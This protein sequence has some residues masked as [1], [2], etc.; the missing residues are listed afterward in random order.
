VRDNI[1]LGA[2]GG[3]ASLQQIEQAARDANIWDFIMSLPQGLETECGQKGTKLSGGQKQR[4][5]IAR[6]LVR[7]PAVLLLDEATSALDSASEKAVLEAL[8]GVVGGR[9]VISVA[10]VSFSSGNRREVS[11]LTGLQRLSTIRDCDIIFVLEDGR[12]AEKGTHAELLALGGRYKKL[13]SPSL[14]PFSLPLRSEL[15]VKSCSSVVALSSN[16]D[17]IA[18]VRCSIVCIDWCDGNRICSQSVQYGAEQA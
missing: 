6:A 4:V 18:A 13:V 17:W 1:A 9:T 5:C 11:L 16:S 14:V 10:H 7:D 12:V 3:K 8:K 2:A 15:Q